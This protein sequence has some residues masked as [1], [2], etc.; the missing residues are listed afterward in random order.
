LLSAVPVFYLYT[1]LGCHLCE[2]AIDVINELH[3]QMVQSFAQ[4]AG[5]DVFYT[6]EKIDI[7]DD[8]RLIERYGSR[9]PVLLSKDKT[10]EIGWP[11]DVQS[12]YEFMASCQK[13]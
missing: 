8:D 1:T 3:A 2:D 4:S 7:A 12:L 9:I 5:V 11:F 10:K 6:I 13:N